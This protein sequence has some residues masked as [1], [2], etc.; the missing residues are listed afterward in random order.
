MRLVGLVVWLTGRLAGLLAGLLAGWLIMW[1][2]G[3]LDAEFVSLCRSSGS[4]NNVI[5]APYGPVCC[6]CCCLRLLLLPP[7]MG[8]LMFLL[9]VGPQGSRC[10]GCL[11]SR[12]LFVDLKGSGFSCCCPPQGSWCAG[13]CPPGFLVFQLLSSRVLVVV[14]LQGSEFSCWCPP[15]VLMFRL[16]SSR[17][18]DAPVVVL[19]QASWCCC[20]LCRCCAWRADVPPAPRPSACSTQRPPTARWRRE[21]RRTTCSMSNCCN[22]F[23]ATTTAG[24]SATIQTTESSPCTRQEWEQRQHLHPVQE[25]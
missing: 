9:S 6:W 16:V 13:C 21:R 24:G 11:S 14:D 12:V 25:L 7:W 3:A 20:R 22:I 2:V 5:R 18:I 8:C 23:T 19:L 17:V 1:L 15:G 4:S 10:S